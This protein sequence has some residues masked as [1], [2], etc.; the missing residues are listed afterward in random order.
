MPI[1]DVF[2]SIMSHGESDRLDY[3]IREQEKLERV[4]Q[5]LLNLL[6]SKHIMTTEELASVIGDD[7]SAAVL[8]K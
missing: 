5:R 4:V 1:A 7:K 3:A 2:S 8:K 6:V